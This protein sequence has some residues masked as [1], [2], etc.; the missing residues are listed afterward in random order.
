MTYSE[1][2]GEMKVRNTK[3]LVRMRKFQGL[4]RLEINLLFAVC[5]E[6]RKEFGALKKDG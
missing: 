4:R 1:F 6:D 2:I 3:L 5:L